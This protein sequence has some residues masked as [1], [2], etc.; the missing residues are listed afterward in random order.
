[1]QLLD[2]IVLAYHSGLSHFPKGLGDLPTFA[3]F[4][5]FSRIFVRLI[6]QLL[7]LVRPD[8]RVAAPRPVI[9]KNCGWEDCWVAVVTLPLALSPS[10][11]RA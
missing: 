11:M 3:H 5:S 7:S 1:M 4:R 2:R 8:L 9:L 10:L 6:L